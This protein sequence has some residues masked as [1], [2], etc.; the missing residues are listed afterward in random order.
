MAA[1]R[2]KYQG[3]DIEKAD[4][5]SVSPP[6]SGSAAQLPPRDDSPPPEDLSISAST[7]DVAEQAATAAIKQRLA[8]LEHAEALSRQTIER[9]ATPFAD[10]PQPQLDPLEQALA[11][12]PEQA[13]HWLRNH[14]Q[15]LLDPEDNAHLQSAH[16]VAVEKT[17]GE[18]F[19]PRYFRAM[20]THLGLRDE[21]VPHRST[22]PIAPRHRGPA[23]SAPPTR[24][25]LSL[26]TGRP[27]RDGTRLSAEELSLAATIGI[28]P[29]EYR[30]GK[31]RMMREKGEGY[32]EQ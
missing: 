20:E 3:R 22:R 14:P 31:E 26:S 27:L 13:R 28:T 21:D 24:D 18:Q 10:D 15:Y 2:K 32:H 8:E 4:A 12:V 6:P 30:L 19:T 23:V 17:G 11:N 25:T 16:Y 7:D 29:E 1:L 9:A 5:P